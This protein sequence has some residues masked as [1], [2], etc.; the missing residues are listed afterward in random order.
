MGSNSDSSGGKYRFIKDLV[1]DLVRKSSGRIGY[2]EVTAEVRKQFPQSAWKET[3]WA[4]YKSQIVTGKYSGEFTDEVKSNLRLKR[5]YTKQMS[6]P[7]EGEVFSWL[8]FFEEMLSVICERYDKNSLCNIFHEMFSDAG[9]LNDKYADGTTGPLREIDPLTFI[10][11]FNRGIK[12]VRRIKYCRLGKQEFGLHSEVPSDFDGIPIINSQKTW[13]FGWEKNRKGDDI[14][15]LWEFSKQLRDDKVSNDLFNKILKIQNIGVAKLTQLFFICKPQRYISFDNKNLPYFKSNGFGLF[16]NLK[17][18]VQHSPRPFDRFVG[19]CREI[20]DHFK[21]RDFWKISHDAYLEATSEKS[22]KKSIGSSEKTR[23]WVI[24]PGEGARVWEDFKTNGI[25]AIGWDGLGDLKKYDSKEEIRGRMQQLYGD[26]TSKRNDALACWEF[27]NVMQPGDFRFAKKGLSRVIGFGKVLSGYTYDNTRKEYH[28]TR[29]VEWISEGDWDIP[30]E[31]R[32]ALKT[33]TDMTKYDT[34]VKRMIAEVEGINYWWLNANPKTWD[35]ADVK[36][37]DKD[38]YM[39]HNENGRKRRVQ[40]YFEH[41]KKGDII[42]G[43]VSSP[44]SQIVALC[45]IT[46]GSHKTNEGMAIEFKKVEKFHVPVNLKELQAIP[47]LDKCEP[48]IKKLLGTL[49]KVT[50]D[51]Y[52]IIKDIIDEKNPPDGVKIY[53]ESEA[54]KDLFI[55]KETFEKIIGLLKHKKNIILQGAPGVGKTFIA[56]RLAYYL[57]GYEDKAKVEMIQFHQSYSYEDFIQGYRPD[58][59]GGFSLQNGVFYDFCMKA[60]D[61]PQSKYVFIIDEIN[62]GNLSKIFGELMMLVESDKRGKEFAMPLTYAKTA[63]TR[64]HIPE[65]VYFIGTMNTADRSLAMVDYALR[66]RFAFVVLQ[67]HFTKRFKAFLVN[68]GISEKTIDL[69]HGKMT[70][71]NDTIRN[72]NKN[73]GPGYCIGHSFFCPRGE[74]EDEKKWLGHILDHEI[75]P[76]IDEYWFDNEEKARQIRQQVDS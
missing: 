53:T 24:S 57:I 40:K 50:P 66:R 35:F 54:M 10:A 75:K 65:N 68:R 58:D 49:F 72:D 63:A 48:L 8:P 22:K 41:A 45:E 55:G 11:Y 28:H 43:Y 5:D 34:F 15:N 29:K 51:E 71:L 56:R 33:L 31:S 70:K 23:Y 64:F 32:P 39:F 69:I 67:P 76:L 21:G 36:I 12:S 27:S 9:G 44:D 20:S 7:P 60:Q 73:L 59:N 74:I 52:R 46:Q 47:A 18:E 42:L 4:W 2:D 17:D 13:F 14:D 38:S 26:D 19:F 1:L 30:E 25:A 61:D 37:G 6:E 62:R 3:H 16:I